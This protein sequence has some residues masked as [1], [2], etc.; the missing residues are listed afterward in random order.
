MS[1]SITLRL[2]P[3]TAKKLK[4]IAKKEGKDR[5]TLIRELLENGVKEKNLE[6]IVELYQTGQVTAWKAAQLAGISLWSF[7]KI[8]EK[9]GVLIRYS[10]QDLD[11]DLKP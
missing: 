11:H 3:Q 8:L 10:Q 2:P 1:E 9:K 4:E 6:H 5:S 7:Y